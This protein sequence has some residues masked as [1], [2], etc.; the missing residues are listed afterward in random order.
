MWEMLWLADGARFALF[1]GVLAVF[2][3]AE[4]VAPALSS[5]ADRGLRWPTNFGLGL[6]NMIMVPLAPLSGLAAAEWAQ[7]Q[8][9]GIL[10]AAHVPWVMCSITTLPPRTIVFYGPKASPNKTPMR[11]T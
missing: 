4:T 7:A 10:N 1:W 2:V 5:S 3:L 11:S 9:F 8:Q 6:T